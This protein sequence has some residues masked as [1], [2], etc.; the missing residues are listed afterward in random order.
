MTLFSLA[1]EKADKSNNLAE[2]LD[3]LDTYFL[4][5]LY[6]NIC[7]SLFEKDKLIFSWL[8]NI[9]IERHYERLN[10]DLLRFLITGGLAMGEKYPS[11]P[12]N[13]L[14]QKNW[15]EICRLSNNEKFSQFK[16]FNKSFEMYEKEW[17]EIYDN[18]L[19]HKMQLP[20]N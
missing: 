9:S 13:W 2:R 17:K 19:P 10:E 14:V 4:Y 8:L 1:L 7:R 15:Y 5:S 20:G 16:E 6:C 11:N 3:N 18:N 12:C